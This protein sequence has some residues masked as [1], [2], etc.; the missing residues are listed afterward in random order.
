MYRWPRLLPRA[1]SWD[2]RPFSDSQPKFYALQGGPGAYLTVDPSSVVR[3]GD[4]STYAGRILLCIAG[5]DRHFGYLLACD[6]TPIVIKGFPMA[7]TAAVPLRLEYVSGRDVVRFVHPLEGSRRLKLAGAPGSAGFELNH[8]QPEG[9]QEFL[10]EPVKAANVPVAVLELGL[11][12]DGAVGLPA[13]WEEVFAR[14][15]G[16]MMHQELGEALL[17]RL[18]IEDLESLAQNLG[19]NQEHRNTIRKCTGNRSPWLGK[20][21]DALITWRENGGRNS[22]NVEKIDSANV[23]DLPGQHGH[24]SHNPGLGLVLHALLRR[25]TRAKR[26]ACVVGSARNEGAY[27]LEW[28]AYHRSV[29]FDHIFLYTNDNTDGSDELLGLLARAGV[30]SWIDNSVAADVL[31]QFRAYSHALSVKPETLDYRWTLIA[32][33]DEFFGFDVTRFDSVRDFLGWHETAR[34][35]AIALPWLIH[36][37]GQDD[38]WSELP[39]IRRFPRREETVNHHIK[40]MF[41]TNQHWSSNCHY[42]YST[43]WKPTSYRGDDGQAHIAKSPENNMALARNP[44]ATHGWIA[45]YIHKS[46]S[47]LVMKILR[48]KGDKPAAGGPSNYD[49]AFKSF[50]YLTRKTRL[51][52]DERTA[53]CG[54]EL[55]TELGMLRQIPGV[56]DCEASIRSRY[57]SSMDRACLDFLRGEGLG[58]ESEAAAFFRSIIREQRKKELFSSH[59]HQQRRA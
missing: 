26:M 5:A 57:A 16:G 22:A 6:R 33:L 54:W 19:D 2:A 10:L 12:I 20:R 34:T 50:S 47:D 29:G 9:A 28:I 8:C 30:I 27:L 49:D 58:A 35:D 52:V 51:I 23:G 11:E 56:R 31:P 38:I 41:R 21:L 25:A 1:K 46:A 37:A 4:T 32:D 43:L 14:L 44:R 48:G 17:C 42:P 45:H 15:H 7:A 13:R 3:F 55:D 24:L 53:R 40:T 59:E 36:V 39:C 18:P